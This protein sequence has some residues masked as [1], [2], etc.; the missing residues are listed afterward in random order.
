[1]YIV[2]IFSTATPVEPYYHSN[3]L[4]FAEPEQRVGA[5]ALFLSGDRKGRGSEVLLVTSDRSVAG[6]N[7]QQR[8]NR[9]R[10]TMGI[11][12]NRQVRGVGLSVRYDEL[13]RCSPEECCSEFDRFVRRSIN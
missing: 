1:V 8:D 6:T 4:T 11:S 12:L 9:A 10:W 2:S 3:H 7:A 5:C 13:A